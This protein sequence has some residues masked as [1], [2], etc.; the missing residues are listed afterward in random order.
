MPEMQNNAS[1]KPKDRKQ[2]GRATERGRIH[3]VQSAGLNLCSSRRIAVDF[4]KM[5]AKTMVS[6]V[7]LTRGFPIFLAL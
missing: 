6:V 2:T 5:L 1:S 4:P 7:L 3:S